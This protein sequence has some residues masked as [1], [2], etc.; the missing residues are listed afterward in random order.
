MGDVYVDN[1]H[2]YL[3]IIEMVDKYND[4]H[5]TYIKPWQC[6]KQ[7]DCVRRCYKVLSYHPDLR[8]YSTDYAFA[9]AILDGKPLFK[10]DVIWSHQYGYLEVE[11]VGTVKET[12]W[13]AKNPGTPDKGSYLVYPGNFSWKVP[14]SRRTNIWRV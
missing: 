11:A 2:K 8:H 1:L 5:G 3:A 7:W 4:A 6:V 14:T 12:V 10:G 13:A 9:V